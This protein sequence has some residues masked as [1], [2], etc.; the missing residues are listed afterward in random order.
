MI[1]YEKTINT[2]SNSSIKCSFC[3]EYKDCV[4][5]LIDHEIVR[6]MENFIQHYNIN[7]LEHS[8]SVSYYSYVICRFLG[9]DYCAAARGGLLHDL[10]LYDW[11]TTKT[12]N[13]LHGFTHPKTALENA[14][15]YYKLNML[16]EDII[17]KHMW[18]LT[19]KMPKYKESYIVS[20][21]D[22]YCSLIEIVSFERMKRI[23]SFSPKSV[24]K[25]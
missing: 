22:K 2:A 5:D 9:L 13:G 16:E 14:K 17:V 11:H 15:K 3:D 20:L 10:F 18:P 4:N 8:I 25:R 7:C 24:Q 19:L 1:K 6:S 21:V 12:R 23:F